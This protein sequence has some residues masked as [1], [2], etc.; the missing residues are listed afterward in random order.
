MRWQPARACSRS[1]AITF[2]AGGFDP[3]EC[4]ADAF[5]SAYINDPLLVRRLPALVTEAGF[6]GA[7]LRGHSYVQTA[8]VDY[9]P[10]HDDASPPARSSGISPT[11][12]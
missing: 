9:R 12:V 1:D 3:L 7:D 8:D 4:C 10:R 6:T 2:A 5:R 11:P